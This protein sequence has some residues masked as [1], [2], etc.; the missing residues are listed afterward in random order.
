MHKMFVND[1]DDEDEDE[2][3]YDS[4][5]RY[6]QLRMFDVENVIKHIELSD[7]K[8]ICIVGEQKSGKHEILEL[9]LPD[10]ITVAP[11]QEGLMKTLWNL[12]KIIISETG[13]G[14]V[15][16]YKFTCDLVAPLM[17]INSQQLT[18]LA[19][20]GRSNL[21]LMDVNTNMTVH[22]TSLSVNE[23]ESWIE[24][25]FVSETTAAL[26]NR[27]TGDVSLHDIRMGKTCSATPHAKYIPGY[28]SKVEELWS[29]GNSTVNKVNTSLRNDSTKLGILSSQ[30]KLVI[31]DL[32]T[33]E[34]P[35][36]RADI[37]KVCSQEET[38]VPTLNF[39]DDSSNISLSGFDDKVY[40]FNVSSTDQFKCT[41]VH[42]GH[43]QQNT[44]GANCF[45]TCHT[46]YKENI[47]LSASENN[48]LHCWQFI[49]ND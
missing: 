13:H 12:R 14:G 21:V 18:L 42:D 33:S 34:S 41:F 16:V 19:S 36:C 8:S 7:P 35:L 3:F 31:Y 23:A 10:K 47:V 49:P 1:S 39:S 9:S 26:C 20:K 24:P 40:V 4:M 32:R 22:N 2:W 45:V 37:G 27:L 38:V 44:S 30:G 48:S 15:S 28:E 17:A 11:S 29:M 46:W 5:K 43:K 25:S 6:K